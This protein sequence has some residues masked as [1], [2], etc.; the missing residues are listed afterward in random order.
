MQCDLGDLSI[1][2]ETE[3]SG[4]PMLMLPGQPS[5]HRI[6]ALFMEPAF[7][8]REGWLRIYPDLPGTGLSP[9][10]DGLSTHD[11]MVDAM[12][13][14][15]DAVIPGQ[16]FVLAGYSAGGYLAQGVVA[17]RG[18][19]LDGVL[20]CAPGMKADA[21]K[22]RLPARTTIVENLQLLAQIDPDFV[23]LVENLVVVQTPKVVDAL[24]HVLA[25]GPEPDQSFN[26]RMDA[27]S[28]A[29]FE[30]DPQRVHFDGLALIVTARQ[31]NICGYQDTWELLD[32]FPRATFAVLDRAGHF[33]GIEQDRL[34]QDLV[35]EW[36][37]RVEGEVASAE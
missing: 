14:F 37:D 34:F 25:E 36:L 1:Y 6:M 3:G 23:P 22:V 20:L 27:A 21:S 9:A 19:D 35:G 12:L 17:S 2:Y 26:A 16:R 4:R 7:A 33:V 31:D 28:P 32:R 8:N 11:Q 30:L 29:A 10:P 24:Y 5:D 15:I 18:A 13:A